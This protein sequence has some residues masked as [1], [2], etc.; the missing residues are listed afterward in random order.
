MM[1]PQWSGL[2]GGSSGMAGQQSNNSSGG[3]YCGSC[4]SSSLPS[5]GFMGA[6]NQ[7]WPGMGHGACGCGSGSYDVSD[8]SS[9]GSYAQGGCN[10]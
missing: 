1:D 6:Q 10:G 8:P 2:A 5:D 4:D 9:N 7:S 3:K